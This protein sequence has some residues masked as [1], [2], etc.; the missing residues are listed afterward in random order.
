MS[1]TDERTET[2]K[3]LWA[4]GLSASQIAGRLGA[5]TRNAVVGKIHR[6]GISARSTTRV[7]RRP[8]RKPRVERQAPPKAAKP[9]WASF[10]LPD[11]R[12]DMPPETPAE[13]LPPVKRVF[14]PA[15]KVTLPE[16]EEH[17]CRWPVGD[18][19]DEDFRFCGETRVP[20]QPYCVACCQVAFAPPRV[21]K[22]D[23]RQAP[24][25]AQAVS[26][27]GGGGSTREPEIAVPGASEID[28]EVVS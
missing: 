27:L 28:L 18:P 9:N 14:D 4:E 11:P 25:A 6:L 3:K 15:K 19:R 13:P 8:K 20:G 24:R 26:E 16:L 22:P 2:L 5:V 23:R 21:N 7:A 10:G 1:W 12:R 17:H